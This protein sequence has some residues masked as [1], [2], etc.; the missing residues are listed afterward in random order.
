MNKK[1]L[2]GSIIAV[3][4][5]IGVSFT[6]VVGYRSVESDM[7]VSPLF[8]IRTNRAIDEESEDL[9]WE[10]VGKG[11]GINIP[12]P[13]RDNKVESLDRFVN[14]IR[15]M[16]EKSFDR[17]VDFIFLNL[18]QIE[19]FREYNNKE[20]ILYL[21]QLR[22]NPIKIIPNILEGE[23]GNLHTY[24]CTWG[25]KGCPDLTV[26]YGLVVICMLWYIVI[27]LALIGWVI[28]MTVFYPTTI[29]LCGCP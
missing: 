20:I 3:A 12:F 18:N 17:F 13:T 19:D 1:I 10:Y 2:I 6:S 25:W 7:K 8:N 26:E 14:I 9:S 5:L 15:T 23:E 29:P 4:V 11:F 28:Q 16:D 21:N 27:F 22:Y 24:E